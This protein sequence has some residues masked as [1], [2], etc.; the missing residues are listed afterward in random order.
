M[1]ELRRVATGGTCSF[2]PKRVALLS[3]CLAARR[4]DLVESGK[5]PAVFSLAVS[6]I[7]FCHTND[8]RVKCEVVA[9]CLV[10]AEALF[11]LSF[12]WHLLVPKT[13]FSLHVFFPLSCAG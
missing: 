5:G 13:N 7:L 2:A 8:T 4:R 6:F 9:H 12:L 10:V 3:Q 1:R 11:I